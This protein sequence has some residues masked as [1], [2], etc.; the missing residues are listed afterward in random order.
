MYIRT[1]Q[2]EKKG[3]ISACTPSMDSRAY[4]ELVIVLNLNSIMYRRGVFPTDFTLCCLLRFR[5]HKQ[6]SGKARYSKNPQNKITR[7]KFNHDLK[8]SRHESG[9]DD[10][11]YSLRDI[12]NRGVILSLPVWLCVSHLLPVKFTVMEF[13]VGCSC[14]KQFCAI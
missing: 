12:S 9:H 2:L 7:F 6:A 3:P 8:H 11:R 13:K 1:L 5:R 14:L 4:G 10:L